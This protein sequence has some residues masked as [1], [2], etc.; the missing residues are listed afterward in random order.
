MRRVGDVLEP[1][2]AEIDE[3]G[4]NRAAHMAPGIGGD[5]NAAG[6][7]EALEARGDIDAVAV[8]VVRRD[9]DIAEIDADAKLDTAILRQPGIAQPNEPLHIQRAAHRIDDAAELD[10]SPIAGMLD[11]AAA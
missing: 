10:E 6:R 8:N 9:D 1:L 5:A 7:G 4:R 3:F 2:L 11:Y